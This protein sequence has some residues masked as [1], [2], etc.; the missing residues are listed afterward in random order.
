MYANKEIW[1]VLWE[2]QG[3]VECKEMWVTLSDT[4]AWQTIQET[5]G[6]EAQLLAII[7]G[8]RSESMR[9]RGAPRPGRSEMQCVDPFEPV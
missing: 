5:L 4:S 2:C 7:P 8:R 9:W 6:D 1:T 3:R